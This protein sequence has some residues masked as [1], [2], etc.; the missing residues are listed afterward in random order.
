M[1]NKLKLGT[2][3][4]EFILVRTEQVPMAMLTKTDY[5]RLI[6]RLKVKYNDLFGEEYLEES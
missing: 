3:V 2:K 4:N 1:A 5:N 6:P